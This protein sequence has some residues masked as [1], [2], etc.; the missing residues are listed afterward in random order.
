[1]ATLDSPAD[2]PEWRKAFPGFSEA[3]MSVCGRMVSH[4]T[5]DDIDKS[6]ARLIG[7]CEEWA[8]R[9]AYGRTSFVQG[10]FADEFQHE[11]YLTNIYELHN[12]ATCP[13]C[14]SDDAPILS[15]G[16]SWDMG[17]PAGETYCPQ[18]SRVYG[19]GDTKPGLTFFAMIESSDTD[20]AWLDPAV[21][22]SS[23]D[24][25]CAADSLG[26]RL[27][28]YECEYNRL[29]SAASR[30]RLAL[31]EVNDKRRE[32]VKLE[33]QAREQ[34]SAIRGIVYNRAIPLR[35]VSKVCRTGWQ[36]VD[37]LRDVAC[38][39]RDHADDSRESIFAEIREHKPEWQIP[40]GQYANWYDAWKADYLSPW[41]AW[42]LSI[43]DAW[44]EGW[45]S[46]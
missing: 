8:Q 39:L 43:V 46:V 1:M 5:K 45:Q 15:S 44:R 42:K 22:N 37:T 10:Y 35:V 20:C 30:L 9:Q 28:E 26:E 25:A 32:A 29:W 6:E 18:C 12:D 23:H 2:L 16:D 27:A 40:I 4:G 17:I 21:H 13:E 24:A 7:T 3:A 31:K 33:R 14:D 11:T 19:D 36:T 34:E 41:Q 38:R